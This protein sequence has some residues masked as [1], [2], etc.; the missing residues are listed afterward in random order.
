MQ[1]TA[2]IGTTGQPDVERALLTRAR[3]GD[4]DAF[5]ALLRPYDR[6]LRGL[7]FRLLGDADAMDDV[8]QTAYANAFRALPRFGGRA[9][10][11]TWL[12]R[13]VTNACL[14][15]LRRGGGAREELRE[16]ATGGASDPAEDVAGRLDL[17]AA[18]AA[19]PAD[20]RAVVLL[21]DAAGLSYA[22]AANALGVREGTVASRLHRARGAL[23]AALG[24]T[25]TEVTT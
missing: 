22:E 3:D 9:S 10:V 4:G 11:S 23:R 20:E 5:V 2:R 1:V 19:L 21:V 15:Q 6:A 8:L 17:E 14:D 7:A 12:Y 18:L 13:I 16:S 24:H 25:G